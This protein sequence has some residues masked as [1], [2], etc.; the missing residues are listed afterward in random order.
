MKAGVP[1][2]RQAR[3]QF[4]LDEL[5]PLRPAIRPLFGS[6]YVYLDE[7]L[8][9]S[10][11]DSAKQPRFNGVWLYT[12]A[13]QIESLRREFASL[14]RRC[15]W[16]SVKSGSGWVILAAELEDFEECAFRACELILRGDQRIGRVTRRGWNRAERAR[17]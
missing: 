4:V 1:T 16:K 12:N 14:P 7:R 9:L 11:R 17:A 2:K 15:F 5:A 6:T 8:L 10:L 13:G 3:F